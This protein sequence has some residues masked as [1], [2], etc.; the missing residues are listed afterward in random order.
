MKKS[1]LK[2]KVGRKPFP[3]SLTLLEK[4]C[5]GWIKCFKKIIQK[6]GSSKIFFLLLEK[7]SLFIN[8]HNYI[9][10][11]LF[12]LQRTVRPVKVRHQ[13]K[14]KMGKIQLTIWKMKWQTEVEDCEGL[15]IVEVWSISY[16]WVNNSTISG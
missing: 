14:E 15:T 13:V 5:I 1:S 11:L 10:I 12:N 8:F 4:N 7:H 2:A 3:V 6:Y 16:F 9:C